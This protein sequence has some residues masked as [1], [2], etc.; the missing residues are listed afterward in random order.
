[1]NLN[2]RSKGSAGEREF[3][4]WLQIN[5]ELDY[6]PTR[7]LDQVRDGGGDILG[8]KPFIFEVKR[9]QQL[10]LRD[11]WIQV[12]KAAKTGETRVVAYRQNN[13]KW[14]FLISATHIGLAT[15][16]IQLEE[17]EAKNWLMQ[18]IT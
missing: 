18:K 13:S 8:V 9:C 1:M 5:L 6:L 7:N 10:A 16:Y 4:R 2:A 14:K 3:A 12:T 17:F 15:G 11:W